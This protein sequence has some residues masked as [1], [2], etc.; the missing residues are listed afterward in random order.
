MEEQKAALELAFN[1]C[2]NHHEQVDDVILIGIRVL[3]S[4]FLCQ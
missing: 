4:F 1:D 3:W 2:N